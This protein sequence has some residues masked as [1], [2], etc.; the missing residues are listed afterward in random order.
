MGKMELQKFSMI[1]GYSLSIVSDNVFLANKI[2]CTLN[3]DDCKVQLT[4]YAALGLMDS[5][6]MIKRHFAKIMFAGVVRLG[7]FNDSNVSI[8][9]QLS[10]TKPAKGKIIQ[11]KWELLINSTM[12]DPNQVMCQKAYSRECAIKLYT[13]C[14]FV[15]E[16]IEFWE[17]SHV[18]MMTKANEWRIE[19]EQ[20]PALNYRE[21][22]EALLDLM[23]HDAYMDETVVSNQPL[24]LQ[25]VIREWLR[26]KYRRNSDS[27][28]EDGATC[29]TYIDSD[30]MNADDV[31]S[32]FMTGC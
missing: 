4:K 21:C 13:M 24:G 12:G 7:V 25:I 29:S 27:S 1:G 11:P 9:V 2:N 6:P 3:I 14:S 8:S 16:A 32:Q 17:R 31:F 5:Y 20:N 23:K 26:I 28:E 22:D 10:K 18:N 30:D 15:A 19:H